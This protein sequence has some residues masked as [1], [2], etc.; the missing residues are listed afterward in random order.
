M[1]D[2]RHRLLRDEASSEQLPQQS[3]TTNVPKVVR[4]PHL[5]PRSRKPAITRRPNS[6]FLAEASTATLG[7]FDQFGYRP[8]WRGKATSLGAELKTPAGKF[9]VE[10]TSHS[11]NFG[12]F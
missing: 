1:S 9:W 5:S 10:P 6:D 2:G 7:A 11:W 8:P 12:G 3:T 4:T